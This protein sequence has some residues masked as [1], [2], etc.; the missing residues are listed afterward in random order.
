MK[1]GS[2]ILMILFTLLF[3]TLLAVAIVVTATAFVGGSI[4]IAVFGDLIICVLLIVLIVKL[5]RKFR[6][7]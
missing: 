4:I 7:K 3:I 5:I 1:K 6:K 2:E